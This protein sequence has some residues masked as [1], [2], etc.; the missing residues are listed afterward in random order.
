HVRALLGFLPT[1][2]QVLERIKSALKP[3]G[4]FVVTEMDFGAVAA[5][6][7]RFWATF[8]TAYLEFADSQ[9]WDFRFGGRLPRLLDRAGFV[10]IDARHIAPILNNV[11]DTP[12]AA[13]ARTWSLTLATLAPKIIGGGFMP[14]AMLRE[15]LEIIRNKNSWVPGPGFMVATA[16][17]P[18][19]DEVA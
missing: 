10:D 6:P 8:W 4:S 9:D 11:G 1:R 12:G 14:E 2:Y 18:I 15:A 7:S 16:R 3:G 13:E 5:G 17:R 19:A